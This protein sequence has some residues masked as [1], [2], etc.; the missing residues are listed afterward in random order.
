MADDVPPPVALAMIVCDAIWIDPSH[1]KPT[2]LGV[3]SELGAPTFPAAHPLLSVFI[4]LTDGKG[5][6]RLK[7][8]L[9]DVDEKNEPLFQIESDLEFPDPIAILNIQFGMGNVVFPEPGEYR[10]QLLGN[11]HLI[12]ERRVLV[13]QV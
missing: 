11:Q 8:Q 10:L 7:L 2:I 12:I 3:F 1:K 5:L 13:R 9:V 6:V 4:D